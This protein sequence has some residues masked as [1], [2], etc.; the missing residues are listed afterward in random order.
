MAGRLD[1][2]LLPALIQIALWPAASVREGLSAELGMLS[3]DNR[4]QIYRRASREQQTVIDI[5]W[6]GDLPYHR[7]RIEAPGT[8]IIE[9]HTLDDAA[10][11]LDKP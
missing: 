2:T 8:F 9:A 5:T 1:P 7:L 3:S 11:F 6:E 10:A 4:R